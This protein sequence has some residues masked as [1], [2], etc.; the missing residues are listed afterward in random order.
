M[1]PA[2][3]RLDRTTLC[4]GE[5]LLVGV[6]ASFWGDGT[7]AGME[8]EAAAAAGLLVVQGAALAISVAMLPVGFP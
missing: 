3:Q 1:Q 6:P 5:H 2:G 7:G 4:L 8:V